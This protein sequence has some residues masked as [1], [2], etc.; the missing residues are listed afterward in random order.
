MWLILEFVV[1]Y[2]IIMSAFVNI[3]DEETFAMRTYLRWEKIL[4][5]TKVDKS[6]NGTPVQQQVDN[7]R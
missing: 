4:I 6:N 1:W 7:V 5:P 3:E 2:F